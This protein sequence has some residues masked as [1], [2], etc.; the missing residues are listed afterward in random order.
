MLV[1]N[2]SCLK[3]ENL[4]NPSLKTLAILLLEKGSTIYLITDG[5]ADQHNLDGKSLEVLDSEMY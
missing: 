3:S 2:F 4:P 1:K 5:F